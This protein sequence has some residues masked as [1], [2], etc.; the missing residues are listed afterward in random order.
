MSQCKT[1][2]HKVRINCSWIKHILL[3]KMLD[4]KLDILFIYLCGLCVDAYMCNVWAF[5]KIFY[6]S[7]GNVV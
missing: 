2:K 7:L 1:C 5:K 6:S 3:C 4:L